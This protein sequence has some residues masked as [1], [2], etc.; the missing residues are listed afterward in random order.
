MPIYMPLGFRIPSRE[1]VDERLVLTKEQM[2]AVDAKK[3]PDLYMV[4]CKDDK[5]F[6]LYDKESEPDEDLGHYRPLED[7]FDFSSPE[8]AAAINEAVD[9]APAITELENN[10]A[11]KD[12]TYT[13]T[14]VDG[15]L[16]GKADKSTTYTKTET[17]TAISTAVN[18]AILTAL[19]TNV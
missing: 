4:L 18:N 11:D 2:K 3:M 7:S 6:Y 16:E 5:R 10:K 17:D 8:A 12:T 9:N 15:A 19:N 14:E 1:P 13:K